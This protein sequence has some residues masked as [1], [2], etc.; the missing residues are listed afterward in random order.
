MARSLHPNAH[1]PSL[2]PT[3]RL[4]A[5]GGL[6]LAL[7]AACG[8]GGLTSSST[9]ASSSTGSG[10]TGGGGSGAGTPTGTPLTIFNWNV[11]NY[12][13]TVKD[14]PDNADEIVLSTTAYANKR[15]GVGAVI[16][17][18]NP[19]IV[20]LS[21]VE[22]TGV[23]QDLNATELAGAY[24]SMVL[25]EGNDQRG[26]DMGLLSKI[27]PDKVV[28][29]KD[30]TFVLAGTPAPTYTF[31]RDCIE[32][33]FTFEGRHVVLLGVHFRS[34]GPPDDQDKRL[35]EAQHTREIADGIAKDDPTAAILV[36]GD[37]N[38]LSNS[39]P[40]VAI[41]GK[42]PD[43]Y[44]DAAAEVPSAERY[45]YNYMGTLELIDHQMGNPVLSA[46]L[47]KG[48][49]VIKHGDGIDSGQNAVSDHSPMMATY[50]VH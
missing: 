25:V 31:T 21:E 4:F 36:L 16:K 17:S 33:H 9:Q 48:T 46:M 1:L 23:L 29:H 32:V 47:S 13:D 34:K 19:D 50:L 49:V 28:S 10:A 43:Q 40:Y 22:N 41:Q 20:V 45:T 2:L 30:D 11:R 24:A 6:L 12:F 44:L 7:S 5:L 26:I 38:D 35:A 42:A 27:A 39:P 15:K 8:Q 18:M 37:F 3:R 14:D